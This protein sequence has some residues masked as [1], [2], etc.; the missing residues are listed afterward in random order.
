MCMLDTH[1]RRIEWARAVLL[2]LYLFVLC[3]LLASLEIQIEG[4]NGW[5]ADLPTWRTTNPAFTWIFGGKPVTGYHIFLNLT[6]IAFFH[7]P[8]L[9][10]R[11]SIRA[12][13]RI[14]FAYSA[15]SVVWDFLWFAYN[16][17]FGMSRYGPEQVW[18]F[19]NWFL[20]VPVDYFVGLAVSLGFWLLPVYF[21][22][23]R[24]VK[25]LVEWGA[26]TGV[27]VSLSAAA[28]A[29]IYLVNVG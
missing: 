25:R 21:R 9:F 16:P 24:L 23:D 27:L 3:S 18:W 8:L 29:A 26:A 4:P 20:G 19:K 15:I 7:F 11:P 14:L 22:Q 10:V 6:L 12:E 5:A 17:Y 2:G 13:S 1:S 28:A